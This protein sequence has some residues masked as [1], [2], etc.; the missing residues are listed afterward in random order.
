VSE[1][2]KVWYG[3]KS[4]LTAI[5]GGVASIVALFGIDVDDG[6]RNA[7]VGVLVGLTNAAMVYMRTRTH[8]PIRGTKYDVG[9]DQ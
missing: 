4:I 2:A 3:S 6:T 9:P 5:V 8:T 1:Q 7:I